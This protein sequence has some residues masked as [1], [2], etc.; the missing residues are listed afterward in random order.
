MVIPPSASVFSALGLLI[1]ELRYYHVMTVGPFDLDDADWSRCEET[2]VEL[3]RR[4]ERE[5]TEA[6]VP[7]PERRLERWLDLRYVGQFETVAV[8]VRAGDDPSA[9]LADAKLVSTSSTW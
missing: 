7:G 9:T 1:S 5:L 8:P 2:F 3:E 6:G 4:G